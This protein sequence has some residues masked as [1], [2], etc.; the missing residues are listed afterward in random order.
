MRFL[1]LLWSAPG[2]LTKLARICSNSKGFSWIK[3]TGI[4]SKVMSFFGCTEEC[5]RSS[6]FKKRDIVDIGTTSPSSPALTR[7][8]RWKPLMKLNASEIQSKHLTFSIWHQTSRMIISS[9]LPPPQFTGEW[10]WSVTVTVTKHCAVSQLSVW[11]RT[12]VT[13]T[14]VWKYTTATIQ[15]VAAIKSLISSKELWFKLS[16]IWKKKSFFLFLCPHS[17]LFTW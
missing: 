12:Q 5:L 15:D 16:V 3:S 6:S 4:D 8:P 1:H 13:H 17:A 10:V 11:A 14:E 2:E 7:L 9:K